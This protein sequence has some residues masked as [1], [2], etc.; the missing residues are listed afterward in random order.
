[1][2]QISKLIQ[3]GCELIAGRSQFP[4]MIPQEANIW[5]G[6]SYNWNLILVVSGNGT[7]S[8]G[9]HNVALPEHSLTV[10]EP[11]EAR[12][13]IAGPVFE[14]YWIHFDMNLYLDTEPK[15]NVI[16]PGVSQ[17]LPDIH[18]YRLFLHLFR[19]VAR[20]ADQRQR[21]WYRFSYCLIQA[22]LLR[23]N[24][25]SRQGFEAAQIKLAHTLLS[26]LQE[27]IS[28]DEIA[29]RC[30]MSR[31]SF[32]TKFTATFGMSPRLYRELHIMRRVQALLDN[33]NLSIGEICRRV[34]LPNAFYMSA[35]FRK[36]HGISP[37][38]YRKRHPVKSN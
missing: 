14:T 20:A 2:T 3:T 9:G 37:T 38:Q 15:W 10:I 21:G 26:N 18:D 28:M 32:F 7:L 8:K 34:N 29:G 17:L 35:R 11:G 22:I 1:M 4:E 5:S 30:G 12:S 16:A 25:I 33:T 19:Q 6:F 13:F 36:I 31:S 24:M 23:G 27:N